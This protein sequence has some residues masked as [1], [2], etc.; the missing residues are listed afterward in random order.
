MRYTIM[1]RKTKIAAEAAQNNIATE[2]NN[3]EVQ[4]MHVDGVE[5]TEAAPVNPFEEEHE[6]LVERSRVYSV[7]TN[8]TE[9]T[10][11]NSVGR[12]GVLSTFLVKTQYGDRQQ[13]FISV[14]GQP[15]AVWVNGTKDG[16]QTFEDAIALTQQ[17]G[18][19]YYANLQMRIVENKPAGYNIFIGTYAPEQKYLMKRII[20]P[21]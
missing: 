6:A 19:V 15:V 1:A 11:I 9:I 18:Q 13:A 21:A 4:G 20:N 12:I 14:A 3:A 5:A 17:T 8:S 10:D 2:L 7:T 16:P